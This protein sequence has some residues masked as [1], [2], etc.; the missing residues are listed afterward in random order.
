MFLPQETVRVWHGSRWACCPFSLVLR[1]LRRACGCRAGYEKILR[2]YDVERPDASPAEIRGAPDKV[3][4]STAVAAVACATLLGSGVAVAFCVC[5]LLVVM[6]M[7][8]AVVCTHCTLHLKASYSKACRAEG[9]H[10][11]ANSSSRRSSGRKG[12]AYGLNPLMLTRGK[13]G[14]CERSLWAVQVRTA[15]WHQNDQ[16]L[17]TAYIDQPGVRCAAAIP[18]INLR[19]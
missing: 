3:S 19:L 15:A 6:C 18:F 9:V 2:L 1:V 17:L 12:A 5:S 16:L 8:R 7:Y 13:G 10:A 14:P 4:G 11:Q